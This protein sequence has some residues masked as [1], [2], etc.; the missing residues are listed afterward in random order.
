[1]KKVIFS[2]WMG[3]GEMSPARTNALLSLFQNTA[4]ANVHITRDTVQDWVHPNFPIHPLFGLLSAVHQCDY[5]RCYLLHVYGG[6]YA[7]IKY[8][9]KK[10]IDFFELLA[11]SPAFGIGYTEI[12]PH[13]VARVGGALELEMM[14]NYQEII[15]VCAIIFRPRTDFTTEWFRRLNVLIDGKRDLL[16]QHP[17]RHPQDRL[18]ALFQDGSISEYPFRWTEVGGDVFHPLVYENRRFI[19]HADMAPSFENY[20]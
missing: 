19:L 12:G 20:R 10:W 8:T 7:D 6:G 2:A 15:G 14:E 4:C 11:R 3:P 5:L 1:M 18:G 13:G 16:I 9:Q 17:A